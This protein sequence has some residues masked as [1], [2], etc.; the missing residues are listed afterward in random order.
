[1]GRLKELDGIRFTPVEQ[2]VVDL[3]SDGLSHPVVT[4]R[5]LWNDEFVSK[6]AVVM[7]IS[8]IRRKIRET[9]ILLVFEK[10]GRNCLG[11]YRLAVRAA[12]AD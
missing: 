9:K 4:V 6:E 10:S 12:R 11:Y 7:T 8:N 2:K 5:S 3:L 1:M